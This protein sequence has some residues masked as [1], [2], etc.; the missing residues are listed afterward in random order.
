MLRADEIASPTD[1]DDYRGAML[2]AFV[3]R[4]ILRAADRTALRKPRHVFDRLELDVFHDA[5][6]IAASRADAYRFLDDNRRKLFIP[7]NA[8]VIV[9][10]LSTAQKLTRQ[11]RR[12]PKQVLLQYIWREDVLLEGER[13]GRFNGAAASML[14]GATLALNENGEVMA[15]ARKPG[16]VPTGTSADAVAEQQL[17]ETRRQEFLDALA[18]RISSGTNWRGVRKR[19]GPSGQADAATHRQS[20]R[21]RTPLRADTALRHQ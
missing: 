20:G 2:D 4:G 6:S 21:W 17:G 14:C 19:K 3:A 15:W 9:A 10:D 18:L 12:L 8:D 7:P 11:A 16:S 5:D 13:F 1:P